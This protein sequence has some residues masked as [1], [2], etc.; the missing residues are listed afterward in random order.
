MERYV[1]FNNAATLES[2]QAA[3]SIAV[4][5][6]AKVV[7]TLP[8]AVLLDVDVHR[9]PDIAAALP[10]WQFTPERRRERERRQSAARRA[11]AAAPAAAL[12][13]G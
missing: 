8:R 4:R 1:F 12:S 6:G 10:N 9:V 13:P 11:M 5:C 3:R 7:G 2:L